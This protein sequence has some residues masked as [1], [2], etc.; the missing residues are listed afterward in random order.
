MSRGEASSRG[1]VRRR[2]RMSGDG[3]PSNRRREG[4]SGPARG[5]QLRQGRWNEA[6]ADLRPP[7]RLVFKEP[8]KSLAMR[9]CQKKLKDSFLRIFMRQRVLGL[10]RIFFLIYLVFLT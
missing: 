8:L 5:D 9:V 2:A 1:E 4:G 10:A 3:A 6:P 7:R